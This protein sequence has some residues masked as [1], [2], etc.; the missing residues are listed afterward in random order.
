M[1]QFQHPQQLDSVLLKSLLMAD[2][3]I[4]EEKKSVATTQRGNMH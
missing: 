4:P 1:L 2:E 3:I